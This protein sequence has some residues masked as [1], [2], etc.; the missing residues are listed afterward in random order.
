MPAASCGH[1]MAGT[2]FLGQLVSGV[3]LGLTE[4]SPSLPCALFFGQK[5]NSISIF[6]ED[7]SSFKRGL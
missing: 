1:G 5:K 4:W 2:T 3:Q 6:V 7:L